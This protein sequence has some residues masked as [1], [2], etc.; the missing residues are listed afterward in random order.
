MLP[1][2]LLILLGRKIS[3]D[4]TSE[5]LTELRTLQHL[6]GEAD[7]L[8]ALT[9]SLQRADT[10]F[11]EVEEGREMLDKGWKKVSGQMGLPAKRRLYHLPWL[12][13][14][15]VLGALFWVWWQYSAPPAALAHQN[16]VSTRPGSK[17]KIELPDGTKVSLN[18][19]SKLTY[20]DGFV[21]GKREVTLVGEAYFEVSGAAEHPL[22]VHTQNMKIT[23]LG[24]RFNVKAYAEDLLA[25]ATLV[26]GKI[27]VTV[28]GKAP[29]ILQPLEKFTLQ[30]VNGG[31]QP[32]EATE[33]PVAIKKVAELAAPETAWVYN[34]LSFKKEPFD[35]VIRKMERWYN[36]RIIVEN[37]ALHDQ[38]MS[39]EFSK[40][41]DIQQA[42]T[43]LQFTTPFRFHINKDTVMIR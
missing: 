36:I 14:A 20:A 32:G 42:L 34:R 18:A 22:V 7:G 9:A 4:A 11:V 15:A 19:G 1:E 35:D 13:A 29:V 21:N 30:Q 41:E 6:H 2:R 8:E 23:V 39:G 28:P 25:E 40:N 12:A 3:G 10:A 17:T 27:S 33:P 26:S 24:T 5:E 31:I 38:L 16:Q 37:E 43:A